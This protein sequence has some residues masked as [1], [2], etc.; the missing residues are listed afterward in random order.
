MLTFCQLW[1]QQ[2]SMMHIAIKNIFKSPLEKIKKS[3]RD[4]IWNLQRK[5]ELVVIIRNEKLAITRLKS[6]TRRIKCNRGLNPLQ[7]QL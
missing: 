7:F 1:R 2:H 4:H 6:R 3:A 5:L